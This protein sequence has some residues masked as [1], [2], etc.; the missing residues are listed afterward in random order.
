[1]TKTKS[2]EEEFIEIITEHPLLISPM[3]DCL[4]EFIAASND[5]K[6]ETEEQINELLM[7]IFRKYKPAMEQAIEVANQ[8][9]GEEAINEVL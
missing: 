1:M 9:K 4:E 7:N 2:T 8:K 5:I 3:T 6:P